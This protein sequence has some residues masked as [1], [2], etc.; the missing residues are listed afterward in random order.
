MNDNIEIIMSKDKVEIVWTGPTNSLYNKNG[1]QSHSLPV[2]YAFKKYKVEDHTD[3][4]DN[5]F[6]STKCKNMKMVEQYDISG[7]WEYEFFINKKVE[8]ILDIY[9]GKNLCYDIRSNIIKYF[10]SYDL[11]VLVFKFF[12]YLYN[13]VKKIQHLYPPLPIINIE[14]FSMRDYLKY[15]DFVFEKFDGYQINVDIINLFRKE[16][17]LKPIIKLDK[18]INN[19]YKDVNSLC[20]NIQNYIECM[21]EI[22]SY[23]LLYN[24]RL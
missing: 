8:K 7:S 4:P 23:V 21:I 11:S 24:N 15:Y 10:N 13:K 3:C 17:N 16:N 18:N 6:M 9:I 2:M 1:P 12:T 20:S 14:H 19:I 22:L 5:C